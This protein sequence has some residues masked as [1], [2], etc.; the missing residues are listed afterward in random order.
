MNLGIN[1]GIS[2]RAGLLAGASGPTF[3]PTFVGEVV[4]AGV[5]Y[6]QIG[7]GQ[8][9]YHAYSGGFLIYSKATMAVVGQITNATNF[10]GTHRCVVND[11]ETWAFTDA[12]QA[13]SVCSVN[14][15]DKA[16]PVFGQRF[17][18]P[19]PGTSLAGTSDI[20]RDGNILVASCYTRDSIAF[21]DCTDPL[22][23]VWLGE[24]RGPTAGTSLNQARRV[25]LDRV[26]KVAYF[27]CDA[28]S[29]STHRVGAIDYTNPAAP[30]GLWFKSDA[31]LDAARGVFWDA[32]NS[33]LWTCSSGGTPFY[34]Q[35][36]AWAINTASLGT[37]PPKVGH[38]K[39]S[40]NGATNHTGILTL[41]GMRSISFIERGGRRYG[42]IASESPKSLTILDVTDPAA[43]TRKGAVINTTVLNGA[44]GVEIDTDGLAY[45][46]ALNRGVSKWNLNVG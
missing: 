16:N 46:G 45:V 5:T 27:A 13:Q 33:L 4:Q 42:A 6:P 22:N 14:I 38:Y 36:T 35:V 1:L 40:E 26:N 12:E 8:Y 21:I 19:T 25:S 20:Q 9:G 41:S 18:G 23:M 34:G 39:A 30:V 44:M 28:S 43:M 24:Y 11:A 29:G 10:N 15:T 31:Q 17:Q 3:I 37:N 32:A 7:S 2:R